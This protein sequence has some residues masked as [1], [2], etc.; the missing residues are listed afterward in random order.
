MMP[1]STT[2]TKIEIHGYESSA[3]Y[4]QE[5]CE[6][7]LTMQSLGSNGM[8]L[9]EYSYTDTTQDTETWDG[10]IWYNASTGSEIT[11]IND[12]SVGGGEGFWVDAPALEDCT[13]FVMVFPACM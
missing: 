10:G 8:P 11:E 2:L 9:A 12:V 5:V 1:K 7:S 3:Y 6:F 4:L 13:E